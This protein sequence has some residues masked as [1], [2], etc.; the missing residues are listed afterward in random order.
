MDRTFVGDTLLVNG[1][2][3]PYLSVGTRKMRFR[4]LNGSNARFYQLALSSGRSFMQIG[5]DGALLPNR[6]CALRCGLPP[7]NASM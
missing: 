7:E 5:T 6:F 3:Q 2:V 4:I 1:A